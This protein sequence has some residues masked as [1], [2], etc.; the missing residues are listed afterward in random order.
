MTSEQQD[1]MRKS[2]K[3]IDANENGVIDAHE[4]KKHLSFWAGK[5]LSDDEFLPILAEYDTNKDGV[6]S[7]EEFKNKTLVELNAL[8][9]Q[10]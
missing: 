4:L 5:D 6:V 8:V 3:T 7:W 9:M 1:R 10:Q 2:F